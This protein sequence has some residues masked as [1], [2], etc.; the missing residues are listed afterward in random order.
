M[1]EEPDDAAIPMDTWDELRQSAI[2]IRRWIPESYPANELGQVHFVRAVCESVATVIERHLAERSTPP[3]A[4]SVAGWQA[5]ATAPLNTSILIFI[6]NLEHNGPGIYRAIHVDMGTGKRWH[7]TTVA[8]GRDL[9]R[10]MMPTHW[11]PLPDPPLLTV[12]PGGGG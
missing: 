6:P 10:D 4:E 8:M 7:A 5:I 2:M 11:R 3:P 1:T 9:R 12:E